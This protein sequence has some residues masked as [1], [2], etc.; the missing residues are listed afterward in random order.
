LHLGVDAGGRLR[1]DGD[2]SL[3][4]Q[5]GAL[6]LLALLPLLSRLVVATWFAALLPQL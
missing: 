1:K 2:R 3:V 5:P 4:L 6:A